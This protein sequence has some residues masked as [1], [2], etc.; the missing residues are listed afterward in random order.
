LSIPLLAAGAVLLS[1]PDAAH[2][3]SCDAM[4]AR[5]KLR[6]SDAAV[7]AK[8]RKVVPI[9]E[10]TSKFVYRARKVFKGKRRF[11]RGDRLRIE[12]SNFG[13]SCGLPQRKRRYGLFLNRFRGRW[14]ASLCTVT[15]ARAMRRA[16]RR[17]GYAKV[18]C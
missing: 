15:S 17:T 14:S 8:L 18:G 13:A 11:D 1:A 7:I 4:P 6:Q 16:A 12:S 3:C 2:A 10:S 5:E 9:T